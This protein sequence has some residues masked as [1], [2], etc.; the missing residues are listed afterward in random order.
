M[1]GKRQNET[2]TGRE[3][4]NRQALVESVRA[5]IDDVADRACQ[6]TGPPFTQAGTSGGPLLNPLVTK[7]SLQAVV[8]EVL[9][10][11]KEDDDFDLIPPLHSR[12]DHT[13]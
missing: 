11:I 4:L 12:Y 10:I 5:S 7:E 8:R 3:V 6:T 13:Q 2:T 1:A 9:E